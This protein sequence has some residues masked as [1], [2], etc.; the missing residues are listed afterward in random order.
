MNQ[1]ISTRK[2]TSAIFILIVLLIACGVDIPGTPLPVTPETQAWHEA[3]VTVVADWRADSTLLSIDTEKC[4]R[5]LGGLELRTATEREWINGLR[6][7]PYM[8][9]GCPARAGGGLCATGVVYFMDNQ[10]RVF[11]SPGENTDGHVIT[12]RHEVIHVLSWCT[13]GSLDH[14]HSNTNMWAVVWR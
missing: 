9:G 12:V 10:F 7:Y 13:T 2:V 6:L 8:P 3:V 4:T 1:V 14:T 11:L 5:A